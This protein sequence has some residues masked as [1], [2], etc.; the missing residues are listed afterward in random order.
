MLNLLL[1]YMRV[2]CSLRH[3][4]GLDLPVVEVAPVCRDLR[5]FGLRYIM[6]LDPNVPAVSLSIDENS[7]DPPII[8]HFRVDVASKT[9][10]KSA[11]RDIGRTPPPGKEECG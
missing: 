8:P 10:K 4:L 1:T 9:F 6:E 3:K 5:L 2:H 7:F 11:Y